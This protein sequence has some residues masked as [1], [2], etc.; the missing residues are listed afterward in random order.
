MCEAYVSETLTKRMVRNCNKNIL[1]RF[2]D[3]MVCKVISY[4]TFIDS[5]LKEMLKVLAAVLEY[6]GDDLV[7]CPHPLD[8]SQD[9]A[10]SS[11]FPN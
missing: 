6:D 1:R 2:G 10:V 5:N 3:H 4:E 8:F 7:I 9:W 11:I